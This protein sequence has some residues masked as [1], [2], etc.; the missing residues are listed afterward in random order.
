MGAQHVGDLLVELFNLLV[1]AVQVLQRE[2]HE[3]TID[4]A[5]FPARTQGVGELVGLGA[6]AMIGFLAKMLSI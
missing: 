2:L 4:G 1:N 3:P 6:E 5:E